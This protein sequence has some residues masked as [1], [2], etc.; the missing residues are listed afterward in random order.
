M[1]DGDAAGLAVEVSDLEVAQLAG[2]RPG[3][4]KQKQDGPVAPAGGAAGVD[5]G[6]GAPLG[7]IVAGVEHVADLGLGVGFGLFALELR[8]LDTAT[9]DVGHA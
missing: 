9:D 3:V 8:A 2:A 4:N 6:L 7:G 1:V 5:A